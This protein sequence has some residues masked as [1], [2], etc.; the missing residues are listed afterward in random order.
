MRA[1][2]VLA[3]APLFAAACSASARPSPTAYVDRGESR[4]PDA[5]APAQRLSPFAAY[6]ARMHRSIHRLWGFGV[7]E[8]WDAL[9]PSSPF[10]DPTLMTNLEIVVNPEGTVD[11]VTI[12]TRSGHLPYD[13]AA[14]DVAYSAAPY[15]ATPPEIRS[16]NGKV[17]VHW[18]FHRDRRQC[19]TSG[20]D[21]FILTNPPPAVDGGPTVRLPP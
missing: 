17:Y 3:A 1:L 5:G 13:V 4:A 21:Y 15:P 16:A 19:A 18:R 8:D 2:I 6:I 9:P 7:L 10:N 12:V 14:I 11:K 20:V